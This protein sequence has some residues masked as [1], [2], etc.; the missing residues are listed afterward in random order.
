[1]IGYLKTM[2]PNKVASSI[3]FNISIID[4]ETLNLA[5]FDS[6]TGECLYQHDF[7]KDQLLYDDFSDSPIDHPHSL[8]LVST[9]QGFKK[10]SVIDAFRYTQHTKAKTGGALL[11]QFN[12]TY[13]LMYFVVPFPDSPWEDWSF[14][15]SGTQITINGNIQNKTVDTNKKGAILD[16]ILNLLPSLSAAM[17]GD[18]II[19]ELIDSD[20]NTIPKAGVEIWLETT[21]GILEDSR[22]LTDKNG[23]AKTRLYLYNKG[24]VKL[25]F[26]FFSGK[27]EIQIGGNNSA[28]GM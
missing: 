11:D 17:I 18:H 14:I 23:I 6:N 12:L 28:M 26:K 7:T 19:V 4:K 20:Q 16:D 1:M 3:S 2:R 10:P 24:K 15:S 13:P 27:M 25:G 21:T 5:Y 9:R 22:I 8:I